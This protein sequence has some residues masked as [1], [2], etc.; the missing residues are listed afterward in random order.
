[1]TTRPDIVILT[2]DALR[3]DRTSLHGYARPT[4]PTL[5]RL[6]EDAIVCNTAFSL[7]PFTQAACVQLFTSTRPLGYGGFDAGAT[8]RPETVFRRF[9]RAGWRTVGL[10]TLHWVNRFFGYGDGFDEEHMLF[11]PNTLV[12][13]ALA[14]MRSTLEAYIAGHLTV[15]DT[16]NSVAPWLSKLFDDIDVYCRERLD[17]AALDR[18]HWPDSLLVE[19]GYDWDALRGVVARHRTA[20]IADPEGYV[21]SRLIP[22][23][24]NH[25]WIAAD[26]HHCRKPGR[27]LREALVRGS[28]LLLTPFSARL[29]AARRYRFRHYVG[30]DSLA[31]RVIGLLHERTDDRPMLVW[32]HFM[33]THVPY[34]SGGGR[35]WYRQAPDWLRAVGHDPDLDVALNFIEERPAD[36]ARQQTVSALYDASIRWTD[37]QIG[38]IVDAIDA[39]G[40]ADN[41]IIVVAGDHGEELG[42]H[43]DVGHY[44]QFY[45]HNVRAP[46]LF[47]KKGMVPLRIDSLIS[48]LDLAPT[49]CGLAGLDPAV[50]W[51]GQPVISDAAA[52][53]QHMVME[54]VYGGNCLF[55]H[56]PVYLGVR[57]R[58][59]KLLWQEYR[60]PADGF[61]PNGPALYDIGADPGEHSNI[62]RPGHPDAVPLLAAARDRLAAIPEIGPR[63]ADRAF[64]P[65]LGAPEAKAQ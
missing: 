1:M 51:E 59:H 40:R 19:S 10:S 63:R 2:I 6:A 11:T 42:D 9:H 44:F 53:R 35:R 33:D 43:G 52:A 18:R 21:V 46:M 22:V 31:N 36:A 20:F 8:G 3:A 55:E 7:A 47:R 14:A 50:G 26:W 29:A 37:T 24:R 48:S 15:G 12:G 16:V 41:T 34:V 49:L 13:V 39:S 25:Q 32:A 58:H 5:E 54:T 62:Y 27:M 30:A 61:S 57:S 38:R 56:R 23:P 60:D 64:A 4:T 28:N 65:H 45:E 17:R